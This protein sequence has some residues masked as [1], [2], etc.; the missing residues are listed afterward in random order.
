MRIVGKGI[1]ALLL[2]GVTS[3]ALTPSTRADV[4]FDPDGPGPLMAVNLNTI[5][6]LPG[7]GLAV[8]GMNAI[9]TFVATM[10]AVQIDFPTLFQSRIGVIT[11]SNGDAQP[12]GNINN[13]AGVGTA[14][15]LTIVAR[16]TE[17]VVDV[18]GATA[19]FKV[20]PAAGDFL[21]IYYGVGAT[22]N[23]ND[24][25]GTGFQDGRLIYKAMSVSTTLDS[26]S[27]FEVTGGGAGTPLDGNGS[28]QYPNIDSVEGQGGADLDW[29]TTFF[30]PAWWVG[31][32][33][34]IQFTRLSTAQ[35][36]NYQEVNPSAMFAGTMNAGP[37][38]PP[39][40]SGP[41]AN[42]VGASN[43]NVNGVG[44]INGDFLG[45][46]PNIMFQTDANQS[47]INVAVIPEPTSL[48]L[49]AIGVGGFGLARVIR[50]RFKI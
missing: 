42:T 3:L 27:N 48:A 31:N 10:G 45:T 7:N 46:A 26:D 8:N 40:G 18:D 5:D 17:R 47:F 30:D 22:R 4:L 33:I 20:F 39:V 2:A 21:E 16:V 34:N 37:F 12:L 41:G 19:S 35:I 43:S 13:Q 24:L 38:V 9:R 6:Y 29:Q 36:L 28:D 23:A 32:P 44:P 50:R 11:N 25:A 15:E 1:G 49:A 14:Y